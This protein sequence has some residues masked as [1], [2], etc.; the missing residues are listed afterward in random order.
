MGYYLA[1]GIYPKWATFVK[2]MKSPL[3][4]KKNISAKHK[5]QLGKM[6]KELLEFYKLALPL[7]VDQSVT[8]PP[9]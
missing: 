8:E 4:N 3:G 1:D 9:N 5:K 2:S 7:F 6:W